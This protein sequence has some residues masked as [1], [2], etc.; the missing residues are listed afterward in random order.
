VAVPALVLFAYVGDGARFNPF[1][2]VTLVVHG[3]NAEPVYVMVDWHETTVV[4][5]ARLMVS[6]PLTSVDSRL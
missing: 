5:V 3:V 1:A 4:D 2:P 6:E